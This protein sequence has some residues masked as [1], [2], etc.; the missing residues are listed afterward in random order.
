[1]LHL[2]T[3][4]NASGVVT[5]A[6]SVQ[7]SAPRARAGGRSWPHLDERRTAVL[8]REATIS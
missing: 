3:V 8:L 4:V 1:M 7:A 6:V 2:A 5:G